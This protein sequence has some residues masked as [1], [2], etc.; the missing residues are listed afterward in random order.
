M[1]GREREW[2]QVERLLRTLRQGGRVDG[3]FAELICADDQW[4][5]EA[6]DALIAASYGPPPARPWPPARGRARRKHAQVHTLLDQ[7]LG[8]GECARRLGWGFNTV[9]RYARAASADDLLRPAQVRR[10]PGRPL[11]RAPARPPGRR[12]RHTGGTS[13]T[14]PQDRTARRRT[15]IP[16]A[17]SR[18]MRRLGAG[19]RPS[20]P[21]SNSG[22]N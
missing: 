5:R 6:F 21:P 20:G 22:G 4:L 10:H 11:P 2:R 16:R 18:R 1:R 3:E 7:G 17:G 9:K 19:T 15:K 8:L 14:P 13:S 12:A